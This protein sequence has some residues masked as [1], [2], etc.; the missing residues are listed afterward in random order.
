MGL[1]YFLLLFTAA[2]TSLA[3]RFRLLTSEDVRLIKCLL[4]KNV[5]ETKKC[6]GNYSQGF[7][8]RGGALGSTSPL[9]NNNNHQQKLQ[10]HEVYQINQALASF[11]EV[12]YVHL[13]MREKYIGSGDKANLKTPHK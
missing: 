12:L 3:L 4:Q 6:K 9:Y 2:G 11:C 1:P 5:K 8:Q 7:T 10:Y 13:P